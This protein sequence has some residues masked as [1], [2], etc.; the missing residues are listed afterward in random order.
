MTGQFSPCLLEATLPLSEIK[1]D[2]FALPLSYDLPFMMDRGEHWNAG[3]SSH[4]VT[5][6]KAGSDNN[7]ASQTFAIESFE[8]VVISVSDAG[9]KGFLYNINLVHEVLD[10][11]IPLYSSYCENEILSRWHDWARVL[12]LP[13][14]VEEPDGTYSHPFRLLGKLACNM[15]KHQRGDLFSHMRRSGIWPV[16]ECNPDARNAGAP[17]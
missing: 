8:G 2:P 9:E 6:C 11:T 4:E 10:L 16:I 1:P 7:E 15:Q 14:L 5:L 13:V 12:S 3:I 17:A